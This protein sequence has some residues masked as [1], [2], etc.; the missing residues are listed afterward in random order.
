MRW[1]RLVDQGVRRVFG[2]GLEAD[3]AH[4]GVDKLAKEV[5]L[6]RRRRPERLTGVRLEPG[7]TYKVV[8]RPPASTAERRAA[9]RERAAFAR[10]RALTR[11]TRRQYAAARRLEKV[12]RRLALARP[13]SR[14]HVRAAQAEAAAGERFDRL[15]TP[16]SRQARATAEYH[17]ARDE[18][19]GLREASFERAR[20]ARRRGRGTRV[21]VYE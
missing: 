6:A 3:L 7:E 10:Y 5:A 8:A 18:L 15:M 1:Q 4:R 2:E 13:G 17:A 11:P 16:T 21:R 19:A 20:A 9:K 14:R 12:Q